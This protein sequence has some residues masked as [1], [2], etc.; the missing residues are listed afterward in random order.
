MRIHDRLPERE[1]HVPEPA[2]RAPRQ[3][4][5]GQTIQGLAQN[6]DLVARD[7]H[8]NG[9][10]IVLFPGEVQE[11]VLG[12]RFCGEARGV[13]VGVLG[14]T[15]AV[16][17]RGVDLSRVE[18]V[19]FER[20]AA[21]HVEEVASAMRALEAFW[22]V[23]EAVVA[24][25][26]AAAETDCEGGCGGG[27]AYYA[28]DDLAAAVDALGEGAR[29]YFGG[30]DAVVGGEFYDGFLADGPGYIPL[31]TIRRIS[32]AKPRRIAILEHR[33]SIRHDQHRDQ[34]RPRYHNTRIRLMSLQR[35][36][37]QRGPTRAPSHIKH[38]PQR[39]PPRAI[40]PGALR[41]SLHHFHFLATL[42]LFHVPAVPAHTR[43]QDRRL[44][45]KHREH[46]APAGAAGGYDG[47]TRDMQDIDAAKAIRHAGADN[48]A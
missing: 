39:I 38:L 6:T 11:Y 4:G 19:D 28:G 22:R 10:L 35:P 18:V 37:L 9:G 31:P 46:G 17:F 26:F 40:A 13:G 2:V 27:G 41:R 14:I 32:G 45:V 5:P 44:V 7:E 48:R 3:R 8:A 42:P 15:N 16:D 1:Q 21:H 23:L 34:R 20:L 30:A 24:A 12:I 47:Y 33:P 36:A 29:E 43:P 25:G